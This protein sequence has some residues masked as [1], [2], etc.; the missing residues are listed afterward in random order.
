[1]A[2]LRPTAEAQARIDAARRVF[3]VTCGIDGIDIAL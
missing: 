1:M 2:D 3:L